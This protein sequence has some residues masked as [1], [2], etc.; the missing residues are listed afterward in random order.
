MIRVVIV[1]Q[2][3]RLSVMFIYL[4]IKPLIL[5]DSQKKHLHFTFL[6]LDH[7]LVRKSESD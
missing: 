2:L 6:R 1:S 5:T 7:S 4:N 3:K